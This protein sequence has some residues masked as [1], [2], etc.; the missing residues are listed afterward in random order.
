MPSSDNTQR[1]DGIPLIIAGSSG[2]AIRWLE[3]ARNAP[4][5][6]PLA[7]VNYG[8]NSIAADLPEY[9]SVT[10]AMREHAEAAFALDLPPRL[11]LAESLNLTAA[12]R[13]GVVCA[14]LHEALIDADLGSTPARLRV[15]HGWLTL[16]GLRVTQAALRR[17]NGGRLEIEVKG[18]PD[19]HQS[20]NEYAALVNAT[21]LLRALLPEAEA[22]SVAI[23]GRALHLCAASTHWSAQI[24]LRPFGQ[25]LAV[26]AIGALRAAGANTSHLHWSYQRG[27]ETL[28]LDGKR[29]IDKAPVVDP[30]ARVLAQVI[31]GATPG[32]S[33][34]DAAAALRL[35]RDFRLRLPTSLPPPASLLRDSA[36]IGRRRP[37]DLLARLGLSGG[38]P[39]GANRNAPLVSIQVPP[40]P[41]EL[42]AF[43]AGV[44]PVVF[45]TVMEEDVDRT[46]AYFGEVAHERRHRKVDIGK[47][48]HWHDERNRGLPRVELYISHDVALA[49]RAAY[50][51]ADTDPTKAIQE[52]GA[53]VGYP[54]CCVRA[55]ADQ[56]D[57]SNNSANRYNSY[58]RSVAGDGTTT[59]PWPWELNNLHTMIAPFYPCSYRCEAALSWTRAALEQFRQAYP[60]QEHTL[61]IQLAQPVLYFDHDH[62]LVFDGH[63]SGHDIDYQNVAI[64]S[65]RLAALGAAIASGNS[66][67][68][69]DEHL[70]VRKNGVRVFELIR[71]DPGLGFIAPFGKT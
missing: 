18:R 56:I 34:T 6:H 30:A 12:N 69:D 60:E 35:A 43:R 68:F 2:Q 55:F 70:L 33:I 62:M 47:Q 4:R 27:H 25:Q 13:C 64:N 38:I 50:L 7:T 8:E 28:L 54:P 23:E 48:D 65:P 19:H 67:T 61:R 5:L 21:A 63:C 58:A 51:Q 59:V 71:T 49:R 42:W 1:T 53:L 10:A 46:L 20:T 41:F 66:L 11:A 3:I 14:P 44:K 16:R 52:L 26:H 29:I 45:L 39:S 22:T 36:S 17:C 9:A 40:E 24:T 15:A 57:R 31:P 37:N 32:D